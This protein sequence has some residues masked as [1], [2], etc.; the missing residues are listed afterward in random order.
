MTAPA[1]RHTVRIGKR[2]APDAD[3]IARIVEA[4]FGALLLLEPVSGADGGPADAIVHALSADAARMLGLSPDRSVGRRL[5][6]LLDGAGLA[7]TLEELHR[8]PAGGSA[9]SLLL[10]R[11]SGRSPCEARALSV[12][13]N[14]LVLSLSEAGDPLLD[15]VGL[16]QL[17]N[18]A[19]FSI[20][21]KSPEG[22]YLFVNAEWLRQ[23]GLKFEDVVG[24]SAFDVFP[25]ELAE[26]FSARDRKVLA[27]RAPVAIESVETWF[28]QTHHFMQRAY[29]VLDQH[30]AI[31]AVVS[32]ETEVTALR[33]VEGKLRQSEQLF[34]TVFESAGAGIAIYG[35]DDGRLVSCNPTY[36][37]IL[38]FRPEEL[39]GASFLHLT[40]PEDRA[41]NLE[42]AR[43]QRDGRIGS[44]EIEK[45]Y[46][47]RDGRFVWCRT[48]VSIV[49]NEHGAPLYA[50]GVMI[51]LTERHAAEERLR[52]SEQN[53]RLI[54]DSVPVLIAYC[55]S[56]TRYH[57][58][59]REYEEWSG[60]SRTEI[61]GTTVRENL[62]EDNYRRVRAHIDA[63]LTGC[64][65]QYEVDIDYLRGG[66]KS[67]SLS[68]VPH[69]VAGRS[70]GHD[71]GTNHGPKLTLHLDPSQGA[72]QAPPAPRSRAGWCR[73]ARAPARRRTG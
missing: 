73:T 5:G 40:H 38:G 34:R 70:A 32:T 67:I 3:D 26:R 62:G 72:G 69:L 19:P 68:Y 30:G 10:P 1:G 24:R 51:D 22:R 65:Q 39:I 12:V 15:T 45:R 52:Q 43:Q 60:R 42:L 58:V 37:A 29:P 28:G 25:A 54:T 50:M 11:G 9:R 21:V 57:F 2:T 16:R 53:I 23:V 46:V 47:R 48:S 63:V 41:R 17:L 36:A 14:R 55:D 8:L 20:V 4:G 27:T 44:F 18:H 6:A 56:E 61:I 59:N 66:R 64:P 31:V 49:P 71:L 33:E 35:V 13:G 7:A